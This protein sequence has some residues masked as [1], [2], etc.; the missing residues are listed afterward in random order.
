MTLVQASV[1][2]LADLIVFYE[3]THQTIQ[4]SRLKSIKKMNMWCYLT[5]LA[6]TQRGW[7]LGTGVGSVKLS[8]LKIGSKERV[9]TGEGRW[10]LPIV[11]YTS[12]KLSRRG[13]SPGKVCLDDSSSTFSAKE[14]A[15]RVSNVCI[16]GSS[17]VE[18]GLVNS[19]GLGAHYGMRSSFSP[20]SHYLSG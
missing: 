20:K 10:H 18:S 15:R 17:M 8:A 19:C 13:R 1:H 3:P 12:E 16:A 5:G 4:I 7:V 6:L 2:G 14:I 11:Y 9:S